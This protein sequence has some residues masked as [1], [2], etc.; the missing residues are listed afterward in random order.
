MDFVFTILC[1]MISFT[2]YVTKMNYM[3]KQ[4][5]GS[6]SSFMSV[7]SWIECFFSWIMLVEEGQT[8]HSLVPSVANILLGYVSM[9]LA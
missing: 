7:T 9:V 2:S 1:G 6:E 4:C 5:Y 8:C 3:Y